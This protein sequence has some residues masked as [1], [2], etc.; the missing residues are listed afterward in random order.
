MM[1]ETRWVER[2]TNISDLIEL[3]PQIMETLSVLADS[4]SD[5]NTLTDAQGLK[6]YMSS[7]TFVAALVISDHLLGFTKQL[8]INLQGVWKCL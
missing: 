5:N 4:S 2:H 8:S 6:K 3:Y 7:H 1:C